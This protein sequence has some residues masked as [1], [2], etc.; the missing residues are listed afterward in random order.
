MVTQEI[1]PNRLFRRVLAGW[2]LILI[3]TVLG[4][5]AGYGLSFLRPPLYEAA[6]ALGIDIDYARAFPVDDR[7]EHEAFRR[8]QELLLADDTLEATRS[9]LGEAAPGDL[10][11]LRQHLRLENRAGRWELIAVDSDPEAAARLA[12]AWAESALA[13]LE[14]ACLHAWRAADLQ[15]AFFALGCRLAP[16]GEGETEGAG[17]V[18]ESGQPTPGPDSVI[19][20]LQ[21]EASLSRGILP[22]MSFSLLEQASAPATP[23]LWGR[24]SLILAGALI[25]LLLGAGFALSRDGGRVWQQRGKE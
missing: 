7:T 21:E 4:G 9:L 24:G 16:S 8:V 6:S 5:L 12:D 23:V 13:Q 15:S 19:Q 11:G 25:G 3:V 17:W 20:A 2:P 22:A 1:D 18:C 14:E 10:Q